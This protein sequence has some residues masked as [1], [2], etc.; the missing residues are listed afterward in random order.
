MLL[1]YLKSASTI[2]PAHSCHILFYDPMLM[3][4]QVH[5][6]FDTRY[7]KSKGFA[8]IQFAH[9]DAAI[10]AYKALDGKHFEGR[11]MH[12]L[13]ASAKKTYKLDD[14]ELSKLPLKKQKQIKRKQGATSSSFSWNSLYMNV[15]IFHHSLHET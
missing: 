11:L 15:S 10:E 12:I 6:A 8:Y 13:A 2:S 7:E 5:V 9:A 4:S 14:H 1:V 3:K